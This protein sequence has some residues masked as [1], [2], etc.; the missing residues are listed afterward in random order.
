[1]ARSSELYELKFDQVQDNDME[2]N[3]DFTGTKTYKD[4]S[5]TIDI[6]FYEFVKKYIDLRPKN[7]KT[8]R[9]FLG[10]RNGKCVNQPVGIN[11]MYK[12]LKIV[13]KFLNLSG[14]YTGHTLRRTAC[15][16]LAN[17]GASVTQLKNAG[18]WNSDGTAHSYVAKSV[19]GKRK[20]GSLISGAV[21]SEGINGN[22]APD[23]VPSAQPSTSSQLMIRPVA[24][25]SKTSG[26]KRALNQGARQLT[27]QVGN[28]GTKKK[29]LI[30][31]LLSNIKF[32]N[33]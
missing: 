32:S 24:S 26:T 16:I 21:A 1:M 18:G 17:Q 27:S 9:F 31:N 29:F 8:N 15:T 19:P 25:S 14:S 33:Y 22:F 13:S 10:Y 3:V 11:T 23:V 12:Q 2:Y 5:F 4:R 30:V 20:I 6:S 28:E 7:C